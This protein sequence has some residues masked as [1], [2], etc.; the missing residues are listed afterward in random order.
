MPTIDRDGVAIYYE[1][2]G[3]GPPLILTHGYSS[4]PQMLQ[5]QIAALSRHHRLILW[6][7]GAKIPAAQKS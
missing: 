3:D 5:G 6:D 4:T 7:S 2:L 1:V